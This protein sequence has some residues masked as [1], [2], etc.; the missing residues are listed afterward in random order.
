[1]ENSVIFMPR[2]KRTMGNYHIFLDDDLVENVSRLMKLDGSFQ[3]WLQN[4]VEAWLKSK[5]L[6]ASMKVK[7]HSNGISD[8][9]LSEILKDFPP[10]TPANFP[11]LNAG[12]YEEFTTK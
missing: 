4:Q 2:L 5:V 1:M 8:E 7:T 10:L 9:M 11:D 12:D 3:A 6:D